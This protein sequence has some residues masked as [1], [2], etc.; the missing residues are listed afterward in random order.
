MLL[1]PFSKSV[2]PCRVLGGA[3]LLAVLV[4]GPTVPARAVA[5]SAPNF[6]AQA[7]PR[8]AASGSPAA[9]S[10]HGADFLYAQHGR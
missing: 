2:L 3:A 8:A 9:P 10:C 7:A 5:A 6:R 4:F 1:H